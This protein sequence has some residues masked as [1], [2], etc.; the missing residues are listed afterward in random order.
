MRTHGWVRVVVAVAAV[1]LAGA[2]CGGDDDDSAGDDGTGI[3][4][5]GGDDG[6][7]GRGSIDVDNCTLLTDAE[8]S[9]LSENPLAAEGDG[10][11]GCGYLPEGSSVADFSIR[12]FALGG[13]LSTYAGEL[14]P[15]LE[16]LTLE[17]IG[18]EAVA[19]VSDGEANFLVACED[20]GCVELVM[21]FLDMDI[22]SEN[23]RRVQDL[24]SAALGR[25]GASR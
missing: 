20:G 13:P 22:E 5:V 25:L 17:G 10:L 23:F 1:V 4:E 19:L 24:A 7:V 12:S 6:S 21:T 15:S 2:A 18:D 3:V 9:S 14:A 16:V 8:E 11:L